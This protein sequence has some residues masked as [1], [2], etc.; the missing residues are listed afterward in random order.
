MLYQQKQTEAKIQKKKETTDYYTEL[1]RTYSCYD[2]PLEEL[3]TREKRKKLVSE[4]K[5]RELHLQVNLVKDKGNKHMKAF[6]RNLINEK[7]KLDID[8]KQK[9]QIKEDFEQKI[10][11]Q[12]L[13]IEDLESVLP[14]AFEKFKADK[15]QKAFLDN[16]AYRAD[17]DLMSS[18]DEMRTIDKRLNKNSA[19][20][21][22]NHGFDQFE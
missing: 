19:S 11:D 21:Q 18:F 12:N 16:N 9:E 17:D 4:I 8:V 20:N 10:G 3:K 22:G 7:Y 2:D 13:Q 14:L 5:Y 15:N 1:A 6:L